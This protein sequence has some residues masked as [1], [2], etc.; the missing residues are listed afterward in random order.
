MQVNV[1]PILTRD[2]I[3][4]RYAQRANPQALVSSFRLLLVANWRF[5]T[6]WYAA[7]RQSGA[8]T[9]VLSVASGRN[10]HGP[11]TA[12]CQAYRAKVDNVVEQLNSQTRGSS[13]P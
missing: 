9:R 13:C 11:Y 5:P 6:G 10:Y 7:Y 8:A 4:G 3:L 12:S 2:H 1:R